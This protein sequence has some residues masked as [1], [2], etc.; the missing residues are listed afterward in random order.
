MVAYVNK[1]A[2]RRNA[3][4]DTA[5]LL[6][7]EGILPSEDTTQKKNVWKHKSGQEWDPD[8]PYG[9]KVYLARKLLEDPLWV[10]IAEVRTYQA[11]V[12]PRDKCV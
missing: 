1:M 5:P 8:L 9:G 10:K 11:A 6:A 7:E 12:A 2:R 4:D 3:G